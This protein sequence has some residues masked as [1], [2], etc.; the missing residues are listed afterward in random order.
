MRGLL[1]SN[2]AMGQ[3]FSA[4]RLFRCLPERHEVVV[5]SFFVFPYLEDDGVDIPK[6]MSIHTDSRGRRPRFSGW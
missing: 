1:D 4:V 2:R 6:G 5:L 3:F